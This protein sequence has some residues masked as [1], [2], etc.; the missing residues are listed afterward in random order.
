M[1]NQETVYC[2]LCGNKVPRGTAKCPV[3]STPLERAAPSGESEMPQLVISREDY[4]HKA[5]PQIQLPPPA[6]SC[7]QCALP[8]EGGEGKC[9]RCGIP[10]ATEE[11]M[12]E[13]PECG[14]LA[15]QRA[16]AC[17]NCGVG[18]EE[19]PTIPGPPPAEEITTP[20]ILPEP[21]MPMPP[22]PPQVVTSIPKSVPAS[23]AG[24][25]NGRGAVNGTGFVN[26][27]GITNGTKVGG[28]ISVSQKRQRTFITRWQFVAVL[29]A[30]AVVIPTFIYLSYSGTEPMTVDGKFKDWSHVT[31]YSMFD[32]SASS[33]INVEEWAVSTEGSSLFVYLSVA[34]SLMSS[35]DVVETFYLFI[36]S[37]DSSSTG[38]AVS[39]IGADYMFQLDG[40][41]GS[42]QSTS[43]SEYP[44]S[45]QYNWSAWRNLGSLSSAIGGS[46]LEAKGDMPVAPVANS[47]YLLLSQDSLN[48]MAV[49]YAVPETGGLLVIRQEPYPDVMTSGILQPGTN[50]PFVRLTLRAQGT[51]GT[52]SD[53]QMTSTG[54]SAGSFQSVSLNVGETRVVD[55]FVSVSATV[56]NLVSSS[57]AVS[58]IS[59]TF[60]DV[61]VIGDAAKAYVTSPPT[62]VEI[63]GAFADWNGKISPDSDPLAMPNADIDI[64]GTGAVNGTLTS[65]FY[66]S[67]SGRIFNGSYVPAVQS[68]PSHGGSGGTVTPPRKTGE[69]YLRV[70]IDSDMNASTGE[71]AI[72]SSKTIGADYLIELKGFNGN[73]LS[74]ALYSYDI[75]R[76]TLVT[77][78]Q[79][80]LG[81]D[82]QRIE[83][84]ISSSYLSGSSDIDFIVETTDW[85]GRQDVGTSA[86]V[87]ASAFAISGDISFN[88]E[89]W[90]ID[91]TT[92]SPSATAMSYQRKLF[93]DGTNFWSFYFD[94][95]N[96]VYKYSTDGG[97]TW[98]LVGQAFKTGSVEKVSLWY[99]KSNNSVYAVGDRTTASRNLYVQKGSVSPALH[100][101]TWQAADGSFA[102]STRN[103]GSKNA[104]LSLDASGYVWILS[105][106]LTTQ[107]PANYNLTAWK[108]N[109]VGDINAFAAVGGL[110]AGGA[111]TGGAN[112]KGS[113]LPAGSG[114]NMWAV[115]IYGGSVYSRRYNG[116]WSNET[117]IYTN[118]DDP[119]NQ[120]MAPPS[121]LVDGKGVIHVVYGNGHA[122]SAGVPKPYIY[123][124]YNRGTT[125]STP[126][127]LDSVSNKL[128]NFY[129]TVSLDSSTGNIYAFWIQTDIND[130]G[131]TIVGKKNVSG[132]WTSLSF[133]TQT[134]DA[135]QYLTSI[136]SAPSEDIIC[137][138]WT[139]NTSGIIQVVFDKLPEFGDIVLPTLAFLCLFFAVFNGGKRRKRK[140][141]DR[142][143]K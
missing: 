68:K 64:T 122:Q 24:F 37:D 38:Y 58:G 129:P 80:A 5:I 13:C 83:L 30:L 132:T 89:R 82:N 67:V 84:G 135:K 94:G 62:A 130:I 40:W 59:T 102:A 53:V 52:V 61:T 99:D 139:Q 11:A 25:V 72:C 125:W 60:S 49:S 118:L 65:S 54:V 85:R 48:N 46:R 75:D 116:T 50:V 111:G 9:P 81:K 115:Y 23:S 26:G 90:I 104:Y 1:A 44:S 106:N 10:L 31:K 98:T 105:S 12:L 57:V 141:P 51:G 33:S 70:Y 120:D 92:T 124:V 123:Y 128:G 14:A 32:L 87:K 93:Y 78:A 121:A 19:V 86:P 71:V 18:F 79:I 107:V 100:T 140:G 47:K 39:G 22:T 42:V 108:S 66:V 110:I 56:G 127:R 134:T 63:D 17:P 27:T 29:V 103:L 73:V 8:L 133:G 3:C 34:G 4:L 2:P 36:D 77:G 96:T 131:R 45:D 28:G 69:D 16:K 142:V 15:P 7:P 6:M 43:I 41:G 21:P 143:D 95:A 74:R 119:G 138:Q 112:I 91:G 136:Y 126:Y 97:V 20:P 137:W 117:A 76:W 101:I 114:S 109:S 35:S 113:I 55:I 88:P